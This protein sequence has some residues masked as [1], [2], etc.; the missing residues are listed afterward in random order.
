MPPFY[1]FISMNYLMVFT[2][3]FLVDFNAVRKDSH[4]IL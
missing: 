3:I 4:A 1:R 2:P